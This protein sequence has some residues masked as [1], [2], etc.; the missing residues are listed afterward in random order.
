M[1]VFRWFE[2]TYPIFECKCV[3][4]ISEQIFF[5]LCKRWTIFRNNKNNQNMQVTRVI[6]RLATQTTSLRHTS[7]FNNA[8]CTLSS[9]V[10][11][12]CLQQPPLPGKSTVYYSQ[13]TEQ[14][15]T[16]WQIYYLSPLIRTLSIINKKIWNNGFEWTLIWLFGINTT[17]TIFLIDHHKFICYRSLHHPQS[18]YEN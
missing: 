3:N 2:F 7:N 6:Y 9:S 17:H 14:Q 13:S 8:Y 12:R 16:V 4:S 5:Y 15:K 11:P 10:R 1:P 18:A